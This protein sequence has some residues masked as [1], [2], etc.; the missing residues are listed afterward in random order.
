MSAD[1]FLLESLGEFYCLSQ[2]LRPLHSLASSSIFKASS[3]VS[4]N[5]SKF[6]VAR[7]LASATGSR[8]PPRSRVLRSPRPGTPRPGLRGRVRARGCLP[9][10]IYQVHRR[11]LR[12]YCVPGAGPR[13]AGGRKRVQVGMSARE[14]AGRG[15]RAEETREPRP[16]VAKQPAVGAGA[17]VSGRRRSKRRGPGAHEGRKG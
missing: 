3:V 6:F 16:E 11:A 5:L 4:S 10:C 17:G 15:L 2:L 9:L 1:G 7:S 8:L 13:G 12:A 14:A